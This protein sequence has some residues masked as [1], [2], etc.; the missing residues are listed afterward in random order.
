MNNIE[1]GLDV[2]D[3]RNI[4]KRLE[5]LRDER[6]NLAAILDENSTELDRLRGLGPEDEPSEFMREY[7]EDN[8]IG[9]KDAEAK[10]LELIAMDEAVLKDWD[11]ENAEEFA[12]LTSINEDGEESPDWEHGETM[13]LDSYFEDFAR[14]FASDMGYKGDDTWPG[15]HIDWSAAAEELQQDYFSLEYGRYTYWVRS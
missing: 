7:M 15:N 12:L 13:I 8:G 4:I 11:E 1:P 5:E 2:I 3:S 10:M 6:E 14:E 9:L